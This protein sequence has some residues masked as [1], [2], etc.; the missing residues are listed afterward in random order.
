MVVDINNDNFDKEVLKHKGVV[1]MDFYG[2]WC[3]PCKILAPIVDKVVE[4]QGIKLAKVDV[5]NNTELVKKFG[6]MSVPTLIVFKDGVEV[7]KSSGVVSESRILELI[8]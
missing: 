3:M 1:I 5:D 6:I 8:K 4:E 7:A 2:T